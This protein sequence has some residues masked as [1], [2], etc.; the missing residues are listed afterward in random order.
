M[1]SSLRTRSARATAAGALSV[2]LLTAGTAGAFAADPS[3]S[4]SK[5][6]SPA[7]SMSM[8]TSPAPSKKATSP[9][10]GKTTSAPTSTAKPKKTYKASPAPKPKKTQAAVPTPKAKE[11]QAAVPSQSPAMKGMKGS[12]NHRAVTA[13]P[14]SITLRASKNEVKAGDPVTFTG[15]T[16]GLKIGS[17]VVLERFNGKKWVP[18]KA[19]TTVKK[20]SS[21][22]LNT[23]LTTKG[24]QKFRVTDGKTASTPVTVTVK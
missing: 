20:G 2:A 12:P 8:T 21:Y 13:A 7:P 16:K 4:G 17:T 15:R 10:P 14:G 23:K 5:A 24:T 11:T 3:P 9:M 22:A 6:A 1:K 19:S 18:M